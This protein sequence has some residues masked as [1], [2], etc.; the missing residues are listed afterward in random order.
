M[1]ETPKGFEIFCY[2]TEKVAALSIIT[3][4]SPLNQLLLIQPSGRWTGRLTCLTLNSSQPEY[5]MNSS[6]MQQEIE[7]EVV[8]LSITY[9]GALLAAIAWLI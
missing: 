5:T 1:R 7:P 4:S 2:S 8:A 9:A 3:R 6:D